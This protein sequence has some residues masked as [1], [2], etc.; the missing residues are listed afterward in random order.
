MLAASAGELRQQF[1]AF[2]PRSSPILELFQKGA[3]PTSPNLKPCSVHSCSVGT[4]VRTF[5]IAA[6]AL[7]IIDQNF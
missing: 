7:I 6:Q 3:L 4:W 1:R 2:G 5:R